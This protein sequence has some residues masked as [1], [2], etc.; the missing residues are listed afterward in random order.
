M[1]LHLVGNL[2]NIPES[3]L[4]QPVVGSG[5]QIVLHSTVLFNHWGWGSCHLPSNACDREW[6]QES[7]AVWLVSIIPVRRSMSS[8]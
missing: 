3:V 2:T 4:V 7:T 6:I 5:S 8:Y 1:R